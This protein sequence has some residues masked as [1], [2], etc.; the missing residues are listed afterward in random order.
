MVRS[1]DYNKA[2]KSKGQQ[3]VIRIEGI[4]FEG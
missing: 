1:R 2:P 3:I 4:A